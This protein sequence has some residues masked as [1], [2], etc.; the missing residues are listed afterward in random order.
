MLW[1]R[2]IIFVEGIRIVSV[3]VAI[4][5]V[6]FIRG[7]HGVSSAAITFLMTAACMS[8]SKFIASLLVCVCVVMSCEKEA[9]ARLIQMDV[10]GKSLS[11]L[12]ILRPLPS[13][14]IRPVKK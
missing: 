12:R 2:T 5:K 9:E 6:I 3:I 8:L 14:F 4:C 11:S 13:A 1:M 7:H 10:T